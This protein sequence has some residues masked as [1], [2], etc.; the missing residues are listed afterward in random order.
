MAKVTRDR[1]MVELDEKFPGYGFAE[2]KGYVTPRALSGAARTAVRE[3]R[4]SYVN[5]AGDVVAARR[6]AGGYRQRGVRES[7]WA[8]EV[9]RRRGHG[10][11]TG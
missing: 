3:H 2:H 11:R 6:A 5:V 8:G 7:G 9:G 1:I 4:F 10:G